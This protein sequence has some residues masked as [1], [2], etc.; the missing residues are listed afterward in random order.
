MQ[1]CRLRF[2]SAKQALA[3]DGKDLSSGGYF[4][5]GADIK[6]N[7]KNHFKVKH[8]IRFSDPS[9]NIYGI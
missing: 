8:G 7:Y 9:H 1:A 5:D 4:W 3:S 2:N 6:S